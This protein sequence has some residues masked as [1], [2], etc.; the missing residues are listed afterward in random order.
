LRL[1]HRWLRNICRLLIFPY[2]YWQTDCTQHPCVNAQVTAATKSSSSHPTPDIRP[3]SDA[4]SFH[5]L[6]ATASED[7]QGNGSGQNVPAAAEAR[8]TRG[9]PDD[10]DKNIA[11]RGLIADDSSTVLSA[12]AVALAT[13]IATAIAGQDSEPS[14]AV[15]EG[16][17]AVAAVGVGQGAGVLPVENTQ[18]RGEPL[19]ATGATSTVAAGALASLHDMSSAG[20]VLGSASDQN[21]VPEAGSVSGRA[22]EGPPSP[23]VVYGLAGSTTPMVRPRL[24]AQQRLPPIT[25]TVPQTRRPARR[26]Q[27][28]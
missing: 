23:R 27:S 11:R 1:A 13:P 4:S 6:F 21:E 26:K 3:S 25:G 22:G 7:M 9:K 16:L 15:T 8:T 10:A 14:Q 24:T 28:R 12:L 18:G 2:L 17:G 20:D 19:S 5:S